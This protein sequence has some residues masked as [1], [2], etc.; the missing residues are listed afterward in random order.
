MTGHEEDGN[1]DAAIDDF[2]MKRHATFSAEP[3]VEDE[4]GWPGE[5]RRPE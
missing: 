1:T 5:V 2:L 3:H 4:A